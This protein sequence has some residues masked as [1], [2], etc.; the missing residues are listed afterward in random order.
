MTIKTKPLAE[1]NHEAIQVLIREMGIAATMRFMNQF[2]TGSGD[3]TKE[4]D[5]L[6]EG[7]TLEQILDEIRTTEEAKMR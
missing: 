7:L 5:A 2:S 3:Y 1:I 6:F 4:R